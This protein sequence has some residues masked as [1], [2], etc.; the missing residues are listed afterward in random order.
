MNCGSG[1]D[2]RESFGPQ[3]EHNSNPKENR[4]WI[5]TGR[6]D[7]EAEAPILRSPDVKSWLTGKDLDDG[8]DWSQ[9]KRVTENETVGW[10]HQLNGHE[11][12]QTPGDSEG[13][14][15]LACCSSWGH[16]VGHN[17][18]TEQQLLLWIFSTANLGWW[19]IT[20]QMNS[21]PFRYHGTE[22]AGKQ[23]R[24]FIHWFAQQKTTGSICV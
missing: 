9:K 7:A 1:E 8:E 4:S 24:K 19:L 20:S 13:Q 3:G 12:E 5:F 17:L 15:S 10:H 22:R 18:A 6:V 23:M 2:S 16:R 11:F 21:I 14:G